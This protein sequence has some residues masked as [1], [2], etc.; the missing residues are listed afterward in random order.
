MKH[1]PRFL[2]LV[3]ECLPRIREISA[4]DVAQDLPSLTLVD[5]REDHEWAAGHIA[6]AVHLARGILERDVES[7]FPDP[8]VAII[9]YCGGGYRSALAADSLQR[10]G[11]TNVRSMAGGWRRWGEIGGPTD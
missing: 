6:G 8:N 1:A 9:L 5:V 11:Y 7:R 4:E 3:A 10:M 2:A